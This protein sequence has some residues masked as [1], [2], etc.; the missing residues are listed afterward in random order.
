MHTNLKKIVY[1]LLDSV[2]PPS[3]DEYLVRTCTHASLFETL[4]EPS[5]ND[6]IASLIPYRKRLSR[7]LIWQLKYRGDARAVEPLAELVGAYLETE[8]LSSCTLVPIPLS[9]E[10]LRE[11]GFNQT[12]LVAHAVATTHSAVAVREDILVRQRHTRPQTAL[13]RK[14]RVENMHGAFAS[15]KAVGD[16]RQP[17][18]LIDDV[19]TTG[20]TL[21]EAATTLHEAGYECRMLALAR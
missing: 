10:R 9:K 8:S 13:S 1:A 2:F 19:T 6:G 14:E 20:S 18:I 11:R 12:A 15:K 21:R 3:G 7:A 17:L 4:Y 5:I 16:V